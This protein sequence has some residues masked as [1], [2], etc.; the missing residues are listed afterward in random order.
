MQCLVTATQ[1]LTGTCEPDQG[2][3][4]IKQN[5]I[6]NGN[7][8]LQAHPETLFPYSC[9]GKETEITSDEINEIS[10]LGSQ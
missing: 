9:P 10:A 5:C 7:H 1:Q 3:I 4:L 6:L 2:S 8:R